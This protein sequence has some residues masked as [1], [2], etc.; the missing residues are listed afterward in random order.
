[1][2]LFSNFKLEYVVLLSSLVLLEVSPRLTIRTR[3]QIMIT[4]DGRLLCLRVKKL[5]WIC[6]L[7]K[8]NYRLTRWRFEMGKVGNCWVSYLVHWD[9][10]SWLRH[11]LMKWM[12]CFIATQCLQLM[13]SKQITSPRVRIIR[14]IFFSVRNKN[15]HQSEV[16]N[17]EITSRY[18][19]FSMWWSNYIIGSHYPNTRFPFKLW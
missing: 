12:F 10:H 18:S 4:A 13:D 5:H 1:M 19:S 9:N 3:I 7:S 16:L 11:R 17:Y 8:Q 6:P 14:S 2:L 15:Y